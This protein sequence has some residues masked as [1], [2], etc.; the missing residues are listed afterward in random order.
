MSEELKY[1]NKSAPKKEST[2]I[3]KHSK[4]PPR[5]SYTTK[6][7]KFIKTSAKKEKQKKTRLSK[8]LKIFGRFA[9][10]KYRKTYEPI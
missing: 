7:A 8:F 10:K 9:S 6:Q 2:F 3:T 5:P 4:H 1:K